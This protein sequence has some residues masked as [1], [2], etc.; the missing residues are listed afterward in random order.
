MNDDEKGER[1]LVVLFCHTVNLP[2]SENDDDEGSSHA[3]QRVEA[4]LGTKVRLLLLGE[5]VI[6]HID[7]DV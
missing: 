1:E 7:V 6:V 5:M 4:S 2:V 3:C